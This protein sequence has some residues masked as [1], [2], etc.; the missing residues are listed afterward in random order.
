MREYG[1]SLT[2]IFTDYD[3]I[4]GRI[5]SVKTHIL[6]YF[7]QWELDRIS[8]KYL[9][10]AKISLRESVCIRSFSG[11]YS[12]RMRKNTYQKNLEYRHFSRSVL[13]V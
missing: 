8:L 12:V 9:Q 10:F 2:R 13:Y 1:F 5:R 7:I 6:T 3:L 11:P 4:R